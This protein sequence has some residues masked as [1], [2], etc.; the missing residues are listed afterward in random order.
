MRGTLIVFA[1]WIALI[2]LL[3]VGALW[4][5]RRRLHREQRSIENLKK[6]PP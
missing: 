4:W 2:L 1:I 6:D 3:M 5:G